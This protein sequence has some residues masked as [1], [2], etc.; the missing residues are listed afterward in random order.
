M[1]LPQSHGDVLSEGILVEG[2]EKE[3]DDQAEIDVGVPLSEV[4][5]GTGDYLGA[6]IPD[7]DGGK[8]DEEYPGDS[9]D[10]QVV[11]VAG[12]SDFF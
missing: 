7:V 9:G 1:K 5:P 10:V 6:L 12:V 11:L 2:D 3:R 4:D 8:D